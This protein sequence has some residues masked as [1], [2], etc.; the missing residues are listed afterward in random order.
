MRKYERGRKMSVGYY[1]YY[2][3]DYP[4]SLPSQR[5]GVLRVVR[6]GLL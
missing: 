3:T 1:Y 2:Y 6:A 4:I 5:F